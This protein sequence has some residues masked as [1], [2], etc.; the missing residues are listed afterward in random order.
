MKEWWQLLSLL[1]VTSH[2][3]LLQKMRHCQTSKKNASRVWKTTGSRVAPRVNCPM[4]RNDP[5]NYMKS[6]LARA[7]MIFY[8]LQPRLLRFFFEIVVVKC[9]FKEYGGCGGHLQQHL[10]EY[11]DSICNKKKDWMS[12]EWSFWGRFENSYPWMVCAL[13]SGRMGRK[14]SFRR[15]WTLLRR[16]IRWLD[17]P[18]WGQL[19]DRLI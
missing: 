2:I 10:Q 12:K 16:D 4:N 1:M 19:L 14:R 17:C 18:R 3:I 15:G 7:E 6:R 13:Y 9:L 11:C 8:Y 5:C